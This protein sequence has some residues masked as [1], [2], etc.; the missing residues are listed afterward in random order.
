MQLG[1]KTGMIFANP[2]PKKLE[3]NAE[4][5]EAA[6]QEAVAEA[7]KQNIYGAASTP[8][9]LKYITQKTGGESSEA[10]VALIKNNAEFGAK[11]AV[12]LSQMLKQQ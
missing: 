11:V 8:F 6:I 12:E 2:I 3:A 10:N 5:M 7:K 9:M 4:K 1:M